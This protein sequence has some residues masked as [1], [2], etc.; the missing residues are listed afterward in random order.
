LPDGARRGEHGYEVLSDTPIALLHD[1]TGWA[2]SAS[3]DITNLSVA[4][5]SL[6]DTYLELTGE[7]AESSISE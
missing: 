6:E 1:L 2:L 4:R 3:A 7:A 5:P